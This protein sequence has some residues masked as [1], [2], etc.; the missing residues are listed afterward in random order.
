MTFSA[1]AASVLYCGLTPVFVDI[2]PKTLVMSF[3][4]IKKKYSK[5]CVAIITVH[6]NGQPCEMEKIVPW[7]KNKRMM[8]IEDCA[9]TCG[10]DYKGK[11][12]GTW[13]DFG[14]FSFQEI[15]I[16]TSGG[17]GG[18]ITTNKKEFAKDLKTLSYH[19]W[20]Q[21]PLVRHKKSLKGNMKVK[22]WNYS[23][24]KLGFKYNMTDLMASI[25]MEQLKKLKFF[26]RRRSQLIKNYINSIKNCKNITPAFPYKFQNSSYWMFTLK[27]KKRDQLI[28]FLKSK[29][30]ATTVY[31]KPLPL[32]P[33]YKKYK[34]RIQ[35]SIKIWKD[36]V[37]IPTYPN[38]TNSQFNYVVKNLKEF[39]RNF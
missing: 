23:I 26:N 33:L 24:T 31:I 16:M 38:M 17:D 12:L 36:L 8:V 11:K 20:D 9:Q 15:K 10:G 18:M 22:H 13:G 4:D 34:N 7:A 25:G 3:E 27:C 29:K 35:N 1:S 14:C 5:D 32:H 30:I 19:G 6:F 37:T 28:D 2:D 21:D 39:D